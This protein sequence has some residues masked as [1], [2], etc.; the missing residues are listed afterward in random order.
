[1]K[2]HDISTTPPDKVN[3][4][5]IKELTQEL[6]EQIKKHQRIMYAQN[7]YSLLI[8]LQGMDAAGK[9][10]A[11]K[12]IFTGINPL[13]C[14]VFSFKAPT[15]LEKEHDFLWRIHQVMP[16]RGMIHIFNRSHYE[17]I[18]VPAVENLFDK[19]IIERRYQHINNFEQL[20]QDN[21]TIVLKFYLHISNEEQKQRLEERLQNPYK[22][23]KHNDGDRDSR[24]KWDEYITI[25]QNI[26]E[27]CNTIP[28]HIIPGD[29]NRRKV[30]QIA[31]IVVEHFEKLD[32]EWPKLETEK[33]D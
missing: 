23:R 12:D 13:G 33:F 1:M 11:V 20:L 2:L 27:K 18:L 4:E 26:F 14:R 32:L 21:N 3:K 30:Y 24:K 6:L 17:D 10:G 15:A 25:Y 8:I 7:K 22:F 31:Q 29:K 16:E 28:R 5:D 9:D 19:E